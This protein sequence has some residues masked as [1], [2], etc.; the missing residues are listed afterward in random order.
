MKTQMRVQKILM[1]VSLVVSALVLVFAL[2]FLTGGLANVY[3][4]IDSNDGTDYIHCAKF[5]STSQSFVSTLV[6]FG[7][8]MIVLVAVMYLMACSSRRNYYITNYIAIG[9]FVVFALVVAVYLVVMVSTIMDLYQND[10]LW[11]S[12]EGEVV[13]KTVEILAEKIDPNTGLP[14]IDP[15]TGNVIMEVIDYDYP[16]VATNYADQAMYYPNYVLDPNQ[17]YNFILGFVMFVVVLADAVCVTLC[18][19]W[20]VLLMKGEKKLLAA[21]ASAES[22]V[23]EYVAPQDAQSADVVGDNPVKEEE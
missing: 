18:T 13:M 11:K 21:G 10:I 20:K 3:R 4:F 17:T 22:N 5:V 7:I 2:F 9:L 14:E 16:M 8:V 6:A 12:G 1:L 19:V 15:I 23:K